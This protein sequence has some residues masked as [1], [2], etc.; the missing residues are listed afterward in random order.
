MKSFDDFLSTELGPLTKYA[1]VLCGN[2][3]DAHD[4]L[5]DTLVAAHQRWGRIETM[6]NPTSYVRSMLSSRHIDNHRQKTRRFALL[7]SVPAPV[8]TIDSSSG[9][10]ERSELKTLLARLPARQR[11]AVVLRYY[12]DLPDQVIAEELGTTPGNV[13]SMTSRAL[14]T[15]RGHAPTDLTGDLHV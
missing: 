6:G 15:L 3:E 8:Q 4:L 12:L 7:R 5:A 10:D 1:R 2:R 11:A 9:V 13:R 14:A